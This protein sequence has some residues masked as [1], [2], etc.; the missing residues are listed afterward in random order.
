MGE[1]GTAEDAVG[2]DSEVTDG[3]VVLVA[4]DVLM[5]SGVFVVCVDICGMIVIAAA[6]DVTTD[7][8]VLMSVDVGAGDAVIFSVDS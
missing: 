8:D 6:A 4:E 1:I 2:V 7:R 3:E 5:P